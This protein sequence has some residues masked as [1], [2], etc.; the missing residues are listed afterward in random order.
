MNAMVLA[1]GREFNTPHFHLFWYYGWQ[2]SW[3]FCTEDNNII[4]KPL[5][6]FYLIISTHQALCPNFNVSCFPSSLCLLGASL[7]FLF[8]NFLPL[9]LSWEVLRS[10]HTLSQSCM[11]QSCM[12]EWTE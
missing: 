5:T 6:D 12:W 4:H 10:E 7:H 1:Y 9:L 11:G 3:L 8:V 2:V